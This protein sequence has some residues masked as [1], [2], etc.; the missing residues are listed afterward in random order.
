MADPISLPAVGWTDRSFDPMRPFAADRMEGRRTETQYVGTPWW[1]M[2]LT[3]EPLYERGRGIMDAFSMSAGDG[4]EC[5]L[6]HDVW[7]PRPIRMDQGVPLSGTK[8]GGGAFDGTATLQSITNTRTI[9]VSGLP[10]GFLLSAGDYVELRMSAL[11]RSLH[12]ILADATASGSGVVT[13]SIRYGLD[14]QHFT[15]AAV[16][17]FEK[18][19]CVMQMDQG[20]YKAPSNKSNRQASFSASEVFYAA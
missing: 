9:V 14:T 11:K 15:T 20:S 8:A 3:S 10:A 1:T 7:R 18:A 5:F 17:N 6:A 4:G 16:V 12:R 2:S 13:L 19:S